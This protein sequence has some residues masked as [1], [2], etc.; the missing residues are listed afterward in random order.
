MDDRTKRELAWKGVAAGVGAVVAVATRALLGRVIT[1]T[2]PADRTKSWTSL[3]VWA[4]AS[5][6]AA[7]LVRAI[8]IRLSAAVWERSVGEP[9][10][11][12]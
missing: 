5:G 9:P 6:L 8:A 3:L 1:D 4:G 2:D 7:G 12:D 10:P 11:L